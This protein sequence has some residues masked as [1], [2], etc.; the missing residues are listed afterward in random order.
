ML[1]TAAALSKVATANPGWKPQRTI[2]L[3][4]W[5][6]EEY[7]LVGSYEWGEQF[8]AFAGT[9]VLAYLNVDIGVEGTAGFVGGGTPNFR[10]LVIESAR[11]VNIPALND[12]SSKPMTAYE[13]WLAVAQEMNGGQA[14][15]EAPFH[16]VGSGSDFLFFLQRLGVST[17]DMRFRAAHESY[18]VYHSNYDTFAYVE[19]FLDPEWERHAAVARV[20][21][22]T[23]LRLV[24][25]KVLPFNW[26]DCAA[27]LTEAIDETVAY[28]S[29]KGPSW[30]QF[31]ASPLRTAVTHLQTAATAIRTELVAVQG[32]ASEAARLADL[33]DRLYLAER[34]FLRDQGLPG[35]PLIRHSAWAPSAVDS[36]AG[37]AF[38][39]ITDAILAN[40]TAAAAFEVSLSAVNVHAAAQVLQGWDFA[41]L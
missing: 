9:K 13:S 25:N 19:K 18:P 21:G 12:V 14:V 38:S 17:I 29:T 24:D 41:N 39:S 35:R 30:A 7:G 5:D 6:A 10:E 16:P 22:L 20:L 32:K 36:Y 28:A 23:L 4:S 2:I 11:D 15:Q 1:A 31:D 26:E 3:A 8:T 40:D 34:A 37:T 33:N 27:K